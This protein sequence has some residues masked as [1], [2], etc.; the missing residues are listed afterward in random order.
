MA[1]LLDQKE[2]LAWLFR[3]KCL[4]V[5]HRKMLQVNTVRDTSCEASSSALDFFFFHMIA[6]LPTR[7]SNSLLHQILQEAAAQEVPSSKWPEHPSDLPRM[8]GLGGL[9]SKSSPL[10]LLFPLSGCCSL[11]LKA[12]YVEATALRVQA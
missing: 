6:I 12:P 3:S 10:F 5:K 4:R 1:W 2:M 9:L 8:W 7:R 11:C